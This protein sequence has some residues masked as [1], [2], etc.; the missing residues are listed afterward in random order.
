MFNKNV[1]FFAITLILL[2]GFTGCRSNKKC[3]SCPC[4]DTQTTEY[5]EDV[6]NDEDSVLNKELV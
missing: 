4:H 1:S 5:V 6:N 2:A 3:S